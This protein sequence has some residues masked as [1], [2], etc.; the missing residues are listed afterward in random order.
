MCTFPMNI[1]HFDPDAY[2]PRNKILSFILIF[3]KVTSSFKTVLIIFE[4]MD[5][6]H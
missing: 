6:K 3:L 4:M 2:F 1:L 5:L